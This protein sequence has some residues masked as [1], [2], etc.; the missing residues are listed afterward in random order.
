MEGSWRHLSHY[1]LEVGLIFPHERQL[2]LPPLLPIPIVILYLPQLG[3]AAL[4]VPPATDG[5]GNK[6]H[7]WAGCHRGFCPQ[8]KRLE[9]TFATIGFDGL[10]PCRSAYHM[11]CFQVGPPF[12]SRRKGG[13]GLCFPP[14]SDW[15]HFICEA[16][17]VRAVQNRE[18]AGPNSFVIP[19]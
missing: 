17:A 3:H 10:R 15:S 2:R 8:D 13:E 9:C 7:T 5:I 14:V 19:R 6:L 16:C 12:T 4:P 1:V 18:L 11:E